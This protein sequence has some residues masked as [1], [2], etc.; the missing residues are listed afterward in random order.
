MKI[1][2]FVGL[3]LIDW[4]LEHINQE[5]TRRG[6]MKKLKEMFLIVN[7]KVSALLIF[8][9]FVYFS[10]IFIITFGDLQLRINLS[11]SRRVCIHVLRIHVILR[12]VNLEN[13]RQP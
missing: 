2:R 11:N 9:I 5:R 8:S 12:I 1:V 3:D 4:L 13:F 10:A 7:S 6:I